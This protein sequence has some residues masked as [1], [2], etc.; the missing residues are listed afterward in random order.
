[1][2]TKKAAKKRPAKKAVT[3]AKK[4]VKKA[5]VKRAVKKIASK[6]KKAVKKAKAKRAVKKTASKA[7]KA[8]KK[9][10]ARKP[11]KKAAKKT[12]K[13]AVKETGR[14]EGEAGREEAGEEGCSGEG[15]RAEGGSEAGR[16]SGSGASRT[17][18]RCAGREDR[19]Q[20]GSGLAVPDGQPSVTRARCGLEEGALTSALFLCLRAGCS[21]APLRIGVPTPGWSHARRH[22]ALPA[23]HPGLAARGAAAA[24]CLDA[25][26]RHA[27]AQPGGAVHVCDDQLAGR[28]S[29]PAASR[30]AAGSTGPRWWRP[31][32]SRCSSRC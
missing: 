14:E 13:K 26:H 20:P 16:C 23:R 12:A 17:G 10:M 25:L 11:A 28:P 32:S 9:V 6:A 21:A 19:A 5:K 4:A 27:V 7:K 15:P 31:S 22:R 1:M 29:V 2:A 18:C 24:A 3:K 8:V 30:Y